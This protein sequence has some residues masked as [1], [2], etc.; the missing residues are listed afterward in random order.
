[1]EKRNLQVDLG[2]AR[3]WYTSNNAALSE[4]DNDEFA[5]LIS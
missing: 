3:K 5:A 1:M 2:T 4:F